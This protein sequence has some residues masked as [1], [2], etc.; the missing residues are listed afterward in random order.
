VVVDKFRKANISGD[1]MNKLVRVLINRGL[2]TVAN[3]RFPQ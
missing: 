1:L 3:V 2:V